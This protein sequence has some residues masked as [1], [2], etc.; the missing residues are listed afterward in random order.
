MSR[1]AAKTVENL[2]EEEISGGWGKGTSMGCF[3][4]ALFVI[5]EN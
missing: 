5:R 3:D 1:A 2:F 4:D